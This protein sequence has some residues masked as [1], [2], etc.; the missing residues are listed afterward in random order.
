V[1]N[2]ATKS[3]AA[4]MVD[5]EPLAKLSVWAIAAALAF[6]VLMVTSAFWTVDLWFMAPATIT[7]YV[8]LK[9]SLFAD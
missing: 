5:L 3:E 9:A 1:P 7:M 8:A 4:K 6:V 2:G